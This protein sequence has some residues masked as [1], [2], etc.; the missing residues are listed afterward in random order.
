M[1]RSVY[2]TLFIAAAG[3]NLNA[4]YVVP[5][6]YLGIVRDISC[7]CLNFPGDTA[8]E[9]IDNN[10]ATFVWYVLQT[11]LNQYDQW[12]GRQVFP[13]GAEILAAS[14]GPNDVRI[15]VSGYLL[16]LA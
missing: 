5:D 16:S 15:R 11:H 10:T 6:G 8:V 4:G 3:A 13:A 1:A 2:S 7:I 9:V 12:E 14:S